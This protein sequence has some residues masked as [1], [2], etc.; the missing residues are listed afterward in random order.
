MDGEGGGGSFDFGVSK[1]GPV[2]IGNID[3]QS[4]SGQKTWPMFSPGA[5]VQMPLQGLSRGTYEDCFK[6]PE[7]REGVILVL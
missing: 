1:G 2:G 3:S 7:G 4:K 5:D 6:L